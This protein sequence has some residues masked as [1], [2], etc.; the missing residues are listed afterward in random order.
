MMKEGIADFYAKNQTISRLQFLSF[1][2][3][4][5]E[6]TA[7][8]EHTIA[9]KAKANGFEGYAHGSLELHKSITRA[10]ALKIILLVF[11]KGNLQSN[12]ASGEISPE[13]LCHD[14][15]IRDWHYQYFSFALRHN[16]IEGYRDNNQQLLKKC[17]PDNNLNLEELRKI[18]TL[19]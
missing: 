12:T 6:N 8:A 17:G 5:K 10:E 4:C 11:M 16:L 7:D 14:L 3:L 19:L 1:I 2:L 15:N 9:E 13:N 18:L